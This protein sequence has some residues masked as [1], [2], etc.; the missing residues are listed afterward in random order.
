MIFIFVF[1]LFSLLVGAPILD[2][3]SSKENNTGGLYKCN[4]LSPDAN[5]CELL[6]T[7]DYGKFS[8]V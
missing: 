5:D 7:A 3:P 6:L 4:A 2:V 1:T 8:N